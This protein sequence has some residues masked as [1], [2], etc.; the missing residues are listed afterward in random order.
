MSIVGV[1]AISL[2]WPVNVF[3]DRQACKHLF[4]AIDRLACI[5][6]QPARLSIT[7]D[8]DMGFKLDDLNLLATP[9]AFSCLLYS[10]LQHAHM[11]GFPVQAGASEVFADH[12]HGT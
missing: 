6:S 12:V 11:F 1:W 8:S 10:T 7:L 3:T 2:Q 5:M 4:I 9:E